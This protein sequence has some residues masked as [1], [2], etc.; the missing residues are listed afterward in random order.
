V[1]DLAW[2]N[3]PTRVEGVFHTKPLGNQLRPKKF[4]GELRDGMAWV[5][6][7]EAGVIELMA[8]ADLYSTGRGVVGSVARGARY[9]NSSTYSSAHVGRVLGSLSGAKEGQEIAEILQ[10]QAA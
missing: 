4:L 8:M 6:Q 3:D 5:R 10:A 2:I 9:T 7:T 1:T